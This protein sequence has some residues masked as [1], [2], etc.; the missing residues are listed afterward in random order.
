MAKILFTGYPGFL[1]SEL[2]PRVLTRHRRSHAVCL[3]QERFLQLAEDRNHELVARHAHLEGRIELITGDITL[4]DLGMPDPTQLYPEVREIYH[5]AAVYDLSVRR[6]VGMKVNVEGTIHLLDFAERCR[7]LE[8]FQ[9]VSTCYVSGAWPGIFS[10]R[11]LDKGQRFNNFYEETKYLAEV[12]VQKRMR[13][14][15]PVTI[16]RPAIVVGDS[17]S[18]ET[19]KYDGPYYV[20]RWLLRQ[21]LVAVLPIVGD[22][23]V[24]R[25]N[26]V[27]R[28]FVVRAIDYLSGVE[29]SIGR[30]YHLA[31]PNPLTVAELIDVVGKATGRI[32]IRVP[33]IKFFAKAAIDFVP[34]VYPLLQI[35]AAVLDYF[36]LPTHYSVERTMQDLEAGGIEIPSFPDYVNNLVRFVHMHPDISSAAM[37]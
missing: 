3:V 30:V 5:L 11:D 24:V 4:P 8:R 1:G 22:P 25:V 2:L 34:G 20:I 33:A 16:Y 6:Q 35:P 14:G 27:P 15:L 37:T 26:V 19:Q 7:S 29:A 12:E 10:E 13:A 23:R 18:G 21:P 31:D 28:D 36:T 17:D 32:V 9:Y